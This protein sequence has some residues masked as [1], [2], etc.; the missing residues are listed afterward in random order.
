MISNSVEAIVALVRQG[1]G[2]SIMPQL[3]NVQWSRDRSLQIVAPPVLTCS[4]TWACSNASST[5]A[6]ASPMRSKRILRRGP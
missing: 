4:G 5:V 2:V 3:A 6:S 1:F